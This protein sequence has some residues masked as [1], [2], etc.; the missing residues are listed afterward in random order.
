MTKEQLKAKIGECETRT[1][2]Q[3]V[4]T[5]AGSE[6]VEE[7]V[8]AVDAYEEFF[9]ITPRVKAVRTECRAMLDILEMQEY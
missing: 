1:E 3:D 9:E 5:H 7:L 6:L 8:S 2:V 4:L